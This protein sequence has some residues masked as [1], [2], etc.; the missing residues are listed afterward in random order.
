MT[1]VTPFTQKVLRA[2]E[3]IPRGQ[4]ATYA[5]I[6]R[7]AGSPQASR[8]VVWVLHSSS[9]KWDLPWHRVINSK[10]CISFPLMSE[11]FLRQKKLLQQEAI[12]VDEYGVVD[13]EVYQWS[14]EARPRPKRP[15]SQRR[16]K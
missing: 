4:V 1:T 2:I 14:K 7:I 8:G 11:F 6:A 15:A 5:Q 13:L 12:V 9:A 16:G 10:G 3:R